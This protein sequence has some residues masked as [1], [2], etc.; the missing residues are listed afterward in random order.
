LL[1]VAD[2]IINAYDESTY[3]VYSTPIKTSNSQQTLQP[4]FAW[5]EGGLAV[6]PSFSALMFNKGYTTTITP[7]YNGGEFSDVLTLLL[8]NGIDTS[9]WTIYAPGCDASIGDI[10]L[11]RVAA[12]F[13]GD[14]FDELALSIDDSRLVIATPGDVND[15]KS[16]CRCHPGG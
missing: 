3:A 16:C 8:Q 6:G 15:L 2:L 14:G 1:K 5:S 7:G 12:D 4:Q 11:S 10:I 9:N 13:T